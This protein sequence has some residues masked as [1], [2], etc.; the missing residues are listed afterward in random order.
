LTV[1]IVPAKMKK[2]INCAV[3]IVH[4]LGRALSAYTVR[5][6]PRE[7]IHDKENDDEQTRSDR[8]Y[9]GTKA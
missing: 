4:I 2:M 6:I 5:R 9:L 1:S 7:I 3:P 8:L